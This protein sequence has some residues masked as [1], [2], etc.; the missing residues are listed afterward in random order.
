V[1]KTHFSADG[2]AQRGLDR[3]GNDFTVGFVESLLG[4]HLAGV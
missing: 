1:L 4:C 3:E 2:A